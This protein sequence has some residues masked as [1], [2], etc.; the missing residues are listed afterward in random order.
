MRIILC[1]ANGKMGRTVSRLAQEQG[2]AI[3]AGIDTKEDAGGL[4]PIYDRLT[5]ITQDADVLLD[6]SSPALLE[7]VLAFVQQ[8]R[9]PL[10]TAVTGYSQQQLQRL[11]Q[12][13]AQTAVLQSGNMSLGIN[14]LKKSLRQVAAALPDWD[15]EIVEKHHRQKKDAPSGTALMLLDALQQARPQLHPVYGRQGQTGART[16]EEAGIHSLRGGTVAGEH[17]V[18]FYGPDE[19]IEITHQA[20]SRA[21]FAQGA[22]RACAF[23]AGKKPGLYTMDDLF[24][25]SEDK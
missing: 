15:V 18:F 2:Q 13:S 6:F 3:V 1:G 20:H 16:Q 7:D 8:R 9:L 12:S 14:I 11:R 19:V 24:E 10:V 21:I 22:L 25:Q 23:M 5:N 4:F 17:S